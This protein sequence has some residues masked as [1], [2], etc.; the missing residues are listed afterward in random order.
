MFAFYTLNSS[1][2]TVKI[3]GGLYFLTGT[4]QSQY[5]T[6]F[7]FLK[8][9]LLCQTLSWSLLMMV[10]FFMPCAFRFLGNVN[11]MFI[12]CFIVCILHLYLYSLFCTF[13]YVGVI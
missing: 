5:S 7:P 13:M 9:Y 3:A 10:K 4:G 1:D 12:N 2:N 8:K 11:Y 6:Y